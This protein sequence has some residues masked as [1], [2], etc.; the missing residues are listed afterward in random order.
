MVRV[1]RFVVSCLLAGSLLAAFAGGAG[2]TANPR[3][4]CV[5]QFVSTEAEAG[6]DFGREAAGAAREGGF[7]QVV[8]S[9]ASTNCGQR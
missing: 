7:G 1:K 3:A 5:G 6:P 4:N 2:A 8:A 9:F